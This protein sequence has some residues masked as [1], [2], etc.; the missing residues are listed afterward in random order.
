MTRREQEQGSFSRQK[1][2]LVIVRS[3]SFRGCRFYEADDLTGADHA[4][5]DWFKLPFLGQPKL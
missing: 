4:I 5:P 3:I 1:S 2:R